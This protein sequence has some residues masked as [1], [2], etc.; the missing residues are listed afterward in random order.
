LAWLLLRTVA[1]RSAWAIPV[2]LGICSHIVLD[3]LFLK[4]AERVP[5][6]EDIAD[7]LVRLHN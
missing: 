5:P 2:A 3:V 6:V 7:P 4:R 1:K